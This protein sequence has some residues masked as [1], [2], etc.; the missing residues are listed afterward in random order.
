MKGVKAILLAAGSGERFGD[1][2]PKQFHELGDKPLYRHSYDILTSS[3]LFEEIIVVCHPD[4]TQQ[5]DIPTVRGG[6]TRQESVYLGLVAAGADTEIVVIHDA[7]RP[8]VTHQ[9][10]QANIEAARAYGAC[11]TC[12]PSADT[13]VTTQNGQTITEI[14]DRSHMRRG[15]TPQSFQYPVILEAHHQATSTTATD[16]CQL[17]LNIDH[18]VH[19]IDGHDHNI[20]VT[21]PIDWELAKL[22]LQ[23][24]TV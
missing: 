15:Q 22:L 16:D 11:D 13:L 12:I 2:V 5:L 24:E 4:W 6:T 9:I 10:L 23:K 21:T 1:P 3:N 7:V 18:P 14:P 20:K 17:V 19:I 8:F